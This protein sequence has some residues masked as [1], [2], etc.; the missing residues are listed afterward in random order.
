MDIEVHKFPCAH[1]AYV[2]HRDEIAE[3]ID[4]AALSA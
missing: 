1:A 4:R 3:L 2:K